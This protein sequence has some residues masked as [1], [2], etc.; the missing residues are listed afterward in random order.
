MPDAK[1]DLAFLEF[2]SHAETIHSNLL[3][4]KDLFRVHLIINERTLPYLAT[5]SIPRPKG[6]VTRLSSK[7]RWG[8]K[9]HRHF[10]HPCSLLRY[11]S[12]REACPLPQGERVG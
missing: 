12:A 10:P 4:L 7:R 5:G 1:P 6:R 9:G 8:L 3:F 11:R 2:G